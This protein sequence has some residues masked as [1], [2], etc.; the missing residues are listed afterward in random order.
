M[1]SAPRQQ[2]S[3]EEL[4]TLEAILAKLSGPGAEL[5]PVLFRFITE[6]VATSVN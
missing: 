6:I 2:L 4:R 5:P 3:D 1:T